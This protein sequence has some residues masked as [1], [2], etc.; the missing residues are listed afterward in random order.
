MATAALGAYLARVQSRGLARDAGTYWVVPLEVEDAD[1]ALAG[2][3]AHHYA[4]VYPVNIQCAECTEV[5]FMCSCV[6]M[7][8]ATTRLMQGNTEE[9]SY[10]G[11]SGVACAWGA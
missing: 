8:R 4:H 6:E 5:V 7:D 11:A 3:A 9:L 1:G 2:V 10:A